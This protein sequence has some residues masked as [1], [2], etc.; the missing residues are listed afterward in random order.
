V[1]IKKEMCVGRGLGALGHQKKFSFILEVVNMF[2]LRWNH[3]VGLN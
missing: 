2:A 1:G 3:N